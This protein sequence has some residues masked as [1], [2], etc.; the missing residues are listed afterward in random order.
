VY[1]RP[2]FHASAALRVGFSACHPWSASGRLND[3]TGINNLLRFLL[4]LRPIRTFIARNRHYDM[5]NAWRCA[6]GSLNLEI[7]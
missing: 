4:F 2:S 5:V 1:V 7:G 3:E 6:A